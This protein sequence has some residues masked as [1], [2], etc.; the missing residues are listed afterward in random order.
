M[1]GLLPWQLW[2]RPFFLGF[3]VH[4]IPIIQNPEILKQKRWPK[5]VIVLGAAGFAESVAAFC[6]PERFLAT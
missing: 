5:V 1:I 3:R 2:Q 4:S 6:E